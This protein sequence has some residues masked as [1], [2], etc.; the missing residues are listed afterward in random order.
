VQDGAGGCGIGASLA[1]ALS[2]PHPKTV[3]N[4]L[5][6]V[7]ALRSWSIQVHFDQ[8]PSFQ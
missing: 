8:L 5:E 2:I 6:S 3:T 1:N 7:F 4:Y